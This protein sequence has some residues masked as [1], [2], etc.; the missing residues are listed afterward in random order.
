[1][2]TLLIEDFSFECIIGIMKE[3]RLKEQK[4]EVTANIKYESQKHGFLD[5][6]KLCREIKKEFTVKKFRL[7][8][9]AAVSVCET[10]KSKNPSIIAVTLKIIKPEVRSDARVGI[11]F[12]K[13][14]S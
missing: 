5:Y 6:M 7:L 2:M 10:L 11:F 4:I 3:E 9:E 13:S 12:E 1:M 14:F 8:E